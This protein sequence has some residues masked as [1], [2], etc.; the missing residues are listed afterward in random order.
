MLHKLFMFVHCVGY[1]HQQLVALILSDVVRDPLDIIASGP[2]LP[3]KVSNAEVLHTLEKFR[4]TEQIPASALTHLQAQDSHQQFSPSEDKHRK[5][6]LVNGDEYSHVHNVIIGNNRVA[7]EAAADTAQSLGYNSLV[8]SNQIQGEARLLGEAYARI[9]HEL[10]EQTSPTIGSSSIR[11][12]LLQSQPFTE[13]FARNPHPREDF[14]HLSGQLKEL[15]L[16]LCLISAGEPIVVVKGTG[17]GGRNQELSLAFALKIHQLQEESSQPFHQSLFLS[18]GTDGQDGP[19][20]AAGAA[21]DT[22]TVA[23]ANKEGLDVAESLENNDSYTLFSRLSGGKH[24]IQTGLTGTNVMD[25]HILL[26]V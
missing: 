23:T 9:M 20:D 4:L 14:L 16:P 1:L 13:L 7:T 8:W 5:I 22:A 26:L 19:C 3:S 18:I 10:L 11:E 15:Q 21:V 12:K 25:L 6:P 24:L 2:T 17:I